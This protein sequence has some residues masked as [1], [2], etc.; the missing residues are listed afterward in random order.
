ME[1]FSLN[2][3]LHHIYYTTIIIK[4]IKRIAVLS[5]KEAGQKA[6]KADLN[7]RQITKH[8]DAFKIFICE[9]PTPGFF[10]FYVDLRS[11]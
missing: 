5:F 10:V 1:G 11:C 3:V 9:A 6:C 2:N 4:I 7:H 8:T